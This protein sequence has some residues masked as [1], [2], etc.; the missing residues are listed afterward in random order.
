MA[1][2]KVLDEEPRDPWG[3]PFIYKH[4]GVKHPDSF[5][6]FSAGP[7]RK[8][9]TDDDIWAYVPKLD[10]PPKPHP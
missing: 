1:W 4:P 7:D 6:L 3:R 8:A 5:D 10:S 9:G 2:R